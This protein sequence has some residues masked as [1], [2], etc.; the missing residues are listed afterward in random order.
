MKRPKNNLSRV[1]KTELKILSVLLIVLIGI[2]IFLLVNRQE[3]GRNE[4]KT[5]NRQTIKVRLL[6]GC[7]LDKVAKSVK[8]YLINKNYKNLDIISWGNVEQNLFIYSKSL[9]VVKKDK[10][11][12]LDEIKKITGIKRRIYAIDEQSIE[13]FDIILGKDY[14]KYFN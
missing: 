3:L 5:E 1:H 9:I 2:L 14:R 12:E 13:D 10:E 7:G 6:N 4:K 8:E 11:K